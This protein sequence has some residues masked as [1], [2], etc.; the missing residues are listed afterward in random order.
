MVTMELHPPFFNGT[1]DDP[2]CPYCHLGPF[3]ISRGPSW[4]VGSSAPSLGSLT[5]TYRKTLHVFENYPYRNDKVVTRLWSPCNLVTTLLQ[6]C[7]NLATTLSQPCH[8]LVVYPQSLCNLAATLSIHSQ[9]CH[10]LV[11]TLPQPC[12]DLV[13]FS[14]SHCNIAATL[15][16][17]LQGCHK[18]VNLATTLPQ[19][20]SIFIIPLQP[21]SNIVYSFTRLPPPHYNDAIISQAHY[22][23]VTTISCLS[24]ACHKLVTSLSQHCNIFTTPPQACDNLT[25]L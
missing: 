23:L 20:C 9:G 11:T 25:N 5:K 14:Q 21:Y 6:P 10:K 12:H 22:N 15:S 19:P 24:Q 1:A 4:L 17:P 18:L 8:N 13:V 7:H 2:S 16:N 3:I